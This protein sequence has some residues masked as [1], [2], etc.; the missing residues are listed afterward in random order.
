M[1]AFVRAVG[2]QTLTFNRRAKLECMRCSATLLLACCTMVT[3]WV[4]VTVGAQAQMLNPEQSWTATGQTITDGTNPSRTTESHTRSGN[5]SF[6]T[7]SVDVLGTDNQYE[8]YYDVEAETVQE[9]ATTKRSIVRTYKPGA[10]G[11]KQL[12]QVTEEQTQ[13]SSDG[14]TDI[15][16]TTSDP[17]SYGKLTIVEREV[18]STTKNSESQDT[19]TTTY[20]I[21]I[22]GNLAPSMQIHEQQERGDNGNMEARKTTSFPDVNGNWQAYEV[23]ER[24]VKED[25]ENR[26]TDNRTSRRDFEDNVSP[27][28]QVTTKNAQADGTATETA[29]TFSV[30]VPGL[31]RQSTVQPIQQATTAQKRQPGRAIMEQLVEQP[32][33]GDP[34]AGLGTSV[35][36]TDIVVVG[37]SGTEETHTITARYPDGYPS[38]VT[39]EI[40]KSNQVPA[41]ELHSAPSGNPR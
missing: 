40:R 5:R 12:T 25:A 3:V 26:T 6:D 7:K 2:Q 16:R 33:P 23:E 4:A 24:A 38:V 19:R 17:D 11:E 31:T 32:Y 8:L 28:S 22:S 1:P 15:L 34:A 21:D 9:S 41:N 14:K 20:L 10:N 27:V 29:S 30:D 18:T 35:K 36:T 37:S 39:V 13:N